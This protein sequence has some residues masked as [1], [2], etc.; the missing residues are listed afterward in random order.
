M[1]SYYQCYEKYDED[2]D[3]ITI[4]T[5]NLGRN[6]TEKLDKIARGVDTENMPT[7]DRQVCDQG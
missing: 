4:I 5:S 7:L 2:D 1:Y 3:G 6:Q